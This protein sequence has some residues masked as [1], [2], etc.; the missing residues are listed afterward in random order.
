AATCTTAGN[1]AYWY[2]SNCGKYFSDS[3]C[4]NEI[5]KASTVIKAT[6]HKTTA[7]AAKAATCTTAGNTAYW[8]C[9]NCG[10]YFSDSACTNEITKAGTVIKATGHKT[11]ATA[12]KAAT[13]TTAG[14][15]AYWYCSN[16]GKYFSDS[17]CTNEIT[18]ASTVIKATGHSFG[19]WKITRE[20]T[21]TSQG[22]K[23]RECSVCHIHEVSAIP[24]LPAGTA[25]QIT[26]DRVT[27]SAGKT[28]TVDIRIKNNPGIAS[29]SL[30]AAYDSSVMTLVKAESGIYA[31]TSFGPVGTEPLVISWSAGGGTDN[32]Q[33]G[34]LARLTFEVKEKAGKGKYPITLSYTEGKI[35]NKEHKNV[36]FSAVSG[37]VEVRSY[38]IGD[39]NGN[40]SVN[41]KDLAELQRYV[42][43]WGNVIVEEAADLAS[44]FGKINMKD[45]AALQKLLNSQ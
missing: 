1:T 41:M 44:P 35:Y 9:S 36:N 16:C 31:G 40:G 15:T 17:A 28:V 8:Y 25:P 6:G 19:P 30:E 13:C 45:I 39:V 14:N 42:N 22:E 33:N 24:Q 11:T 21:T 34:L 18:K 20:P 26:A 27:A 29:L 4:T 3:A 5:T 38:L 7:T 23:E 37:S 12:A 32:I 2:C 43:G 10:K